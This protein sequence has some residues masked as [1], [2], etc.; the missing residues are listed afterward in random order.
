MKPYTC[1]V[2]LR[3]AVI[4]IYHWIYYVSLLILVECTGYKQSVTGCGSQRRH[5]VV[6]QRKLVWTAWSS[7]SNWIWLRW[8]TFTLKVVFVEHHKHFNEY[9][10]QRSQIQFEDE[11]HAVY[12]SFRW[13]TTTCLRWEPQPVTLC[14]YLVEWLLV[15]HRSWQTRTG[16]KTQGDRA[17][18]APV[19]LFGHRI[20]F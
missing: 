9:V 10:S 7:S 13:V 17:R 20:F 14:L 8:E 3:N 5:V 16:M 11:D 2:V 12:I 6:T 4:V 18:H 15:S 1:I 19:S